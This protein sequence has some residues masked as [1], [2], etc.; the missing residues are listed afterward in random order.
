MST[1]TD[2]GRTCAEAAELLG[3]LFSA[4]ELQRKADRG[5]IPHHRGSR[6]CVRFFNDDLRDIKRMTRREP[7][8]QK[9]GLEIVADEHGAAS[10]DPFRATARSRAAHARKPA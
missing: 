1:S 5:E 2:T 10:P 7:K 4:S 9:S 6:N 8:P 3:R